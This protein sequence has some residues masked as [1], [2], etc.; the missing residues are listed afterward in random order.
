MKTV[1]LEKDYS[2][3]LSSNVV[4]FIYPD[5]IFIPIYKGY[6]L[7]VKNKEQIK[8]EQLL[9][10]NDQNVGIYSPISGIVVGAKECMMSNGEMQKCLVIENDFKEKMQKRTTMRKNLKQLSQN[11]FLEILTN[12]AVLNSD[13]LSELLIDLF[14]NKSFNRI[15][16]NGI[17][18]EPY[19]ASKIFLFKNYASEI[20]E[21]LSFLGRIFSTKDNIVVLKNNERENIESFANILGTYPEISLTVVPD[22]YPIG[23]KEVLKDYLEF[24]LD[25]TLIL[26]PENVIAC[27]SA[28]KK[29]KL[30]TE[31]YITITGEAIVNPIVVNA[32]LGSSV[33][34]IVDENIKFLNNE[35]V[36]YT[37]N[38]L[39]TGKTLDIDDLVVTSDLDGIIISYNKNYSENECIKCGKCSEVCPVGIN[40]NL[41]FNKHKNLAEKDKCINCGLCTYICPVYINFKERIEELK[42]EK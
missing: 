27:Y 42:N 18:D 9:L 19:L 34:K 38:G 24:S 4:D 3:K 41:I 17:E 23:K 21:T 15:L 16:I 28:I 39:M 22:I 36:N 40:P 6:K 11:D 29:N 31:K 13:K 10:I 5:H 14:K 26:S 8:K 1:T 35:S 37:I 30:I 33:K 12:K 25:D 7:Q 2:I 20:L 32:K